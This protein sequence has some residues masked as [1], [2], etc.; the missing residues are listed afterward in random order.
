MP[1][2]S[3]VMLSFPAANRDPA[4]FPQADTFVIDRPQNRHLAFGVGIPPLHRVQ[5]RPHGAAG[6]PGRLVAP[7][8]DVHRRPRPPGGAHRRRRH[9]RSALGA[10]AHRLTA[11]RLAGNGLA[12]AAA[13]SVRA[14]GRCLVPCAVGD[15]VACQRRSCVAT[16]AGCSC[17]R[18]G[19]SALDGALLVGR[20]G[21][22]P[23]RT[24]TSKA[25]SKSGVPF[26]QRCT[27]AGR[28]VERNRP[29]RRSG[30]T[31]RG[32][33]RRDDHDGIDQPSA[34]VRGAEPRHCPTVV[35]LQPDVHAIAVVDDTRA[36]STIVIRQRGL[37]EWPACRRRA[38]SSASPVPDG[39]TR[40][41]PSAG[42]PG[43]CP[44]TPSPLLGGPS[45]R[46]HPS[47]SDAPRSTARRWGSC[48]QRTSLASLVDWIDPP[49]GSTPITTSMEPCRTGVWRTS[50][51]ST[52]R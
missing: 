5:H 15:A 31:G 7:L 29:H 25:A 21:A 18:S 27:R 24:S 17:R 26:R 4:V 49:S 47:I 6:G 33:R 32:S 9:P 2:G 51:S 12:A 19:A 1:A 23:R 30:R 36:A 3:H 13:G 45:A 37:D 20:P 41:E 16:M 34:R 10:P 22:D 50:R 46:L 28:R 52:S 38:H 11:G 44:T 8:R 48:A 14:V 35:A 39:P 42:S 43:R 40:A